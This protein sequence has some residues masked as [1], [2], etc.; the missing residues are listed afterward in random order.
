MTDREAV[1]D[2]MLTAAGRKAVELRLI[3]RGGFVDVNEENRRKVKQVVEA[4]LA[5]DRRDE[6]QARI[7]RLTAERDELFAYAVDLQQTLDCDLDKGVI[8]GREDSAAAVRDALV[9]RKG[10]NHA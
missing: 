8:P 3:P 7:D 1:T 4:A 9:R 5:A 6:H 2:E 10:I